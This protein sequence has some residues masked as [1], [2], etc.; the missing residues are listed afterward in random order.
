MT[1]TPENQT[2]SRDGPIQALA[3]AQRRYLC[4]FV[5]CVEG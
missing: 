3:S 5:Q 4:G 2:T 1:P